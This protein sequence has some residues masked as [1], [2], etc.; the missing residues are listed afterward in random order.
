MAPG[1]AFS[2]G[3]FAELSVGA[4]AGEV[5]WLFAVSARGLVRADVLR[6]SPG[7]RSFG[8]TDAAFETAFAVEEDREDL[9]A[10]AVVMAGTEASFFCGD[11]AVSPA[12]FPAALVVPVI[13]RLRGEAVFCPSAF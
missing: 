7:I 10:S 13:R 2:E 12:D 4:V 8:E 9:T 5:W 11:G 6:A 1:S 3:L